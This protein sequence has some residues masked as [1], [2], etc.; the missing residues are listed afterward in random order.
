MGKSSVAMEHCLKCHGEFNWLRRKALSTETK[1]K[2]RKIR[3]SLEIKR[4]NG[5]V[6]N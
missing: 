4:S 2:S 6:A 1:Y 3:E 5:T